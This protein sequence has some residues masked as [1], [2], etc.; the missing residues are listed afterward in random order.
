MKCF[1]SEEM[2][3]F[4]Q[5]QMTFLF[6]PK[7][8]V[9]QKIAYSLTSPCSYLPSQWPF[10]NSIRKPHSHP[11]SHALSAHTQ[12]T[13]LCVPSLPQHQTFCQLFGHWILPFSWH[14]VTGGGR[15][16][17]ELHQGC[18]FPMALRDSLQPQGSSPLPT[19]HFKA[20]WAQGW[21]SPCAAALSPPQHTGEVRKPR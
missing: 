2:Q 10:H 20:L 9:N 15:G 6:H 14:G 17:S 1:I 21:G 7:E 12:V 5:L 13:V 19:S 18:S 16:S 8:L 3:H 4:I 11:L